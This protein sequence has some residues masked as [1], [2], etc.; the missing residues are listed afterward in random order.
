MPITPDH[1]GK[2]I[3]VGDACM[4]VHLRIKDILADMQIPYETTLGGTC[5]GSVAMLSRLSVPT[6]FLGT[7]GNDY[8]GRFILKELRALHID[9]DLTI[10]KEELNT[11]N[12]YAFIDEEGERHLWGFPRSEQAYPD[13]D[14]ERIDLG[15][16]RTALWLHTSGMSMLAKGNIRESIPELFRIA[17]EAG[18]PTSLDLN[19]RVG[20][21]SLLDPM[22]VEAI[23][24]TLPFVRYLTGSAMDEF[25]SFCPCKDYK[26]SARHFA[27]DG[28]TVIARMGKD[29]CLALYD[30]KEVFIPSY[31]VEVK[32]TTGAGDCFNAGFI[33]AMLEGR[34]IEDA[35]RY[36]S[37]V[38]AYKISGNMKNEKIDRQIIE[39]FMNQ[40]AL[41]GER[42]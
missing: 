30:G 42:T 13:L 21:L 15:K 5:G 10:V 11:V 20:D 29:G 31:D 36:A 14:M 22:A 27:K 6:A 33:A 41:R 7:L 35:C 19:T 1:Y 8:A 26:D 28:R 40:T 23:R 17:F 9:T 4:D 16:I 39:D 18:V 37:A 25:Y 32:N 34:N 2:V 3:V 38:A 24:K 12:V